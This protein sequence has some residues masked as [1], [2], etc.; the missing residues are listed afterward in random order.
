MKLRLFF[1]HILLLCA[2][3]SY[4]DQKTFLV[5]GGTTGW[6]GQKI[7][8][9]INEQGHI[10]IAAQSRLE[11]RHHIEQ[12]ICNLKPDFIINAAGVVGRPNADWCEDNK[13]ETIR[14]NLIGALNLADI[15]HKYN[16]HMTNIG[17]GCIYEY[18][19]AHPLKSG[20]GFTE[21]DTPNFEGSFYSK[22]KKMLDILLLC[23]PNVL[24]LRFR[25]PISSDLHP[26]NFV[27]K[28]SKYQKII[29]IPN[30]MTILDDLLPLI[31][32]MALMKLAGNY[33]FVNPGAISHNEILELYKQYIDPTFTYVNF[34]VEEQ[35]KVLKALRS[36]T[37][38]D[39]HKLL[40]VF[41]HIP[42]IKT[43]IIRVF[44]RMQQNHHEQ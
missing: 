14:S 23:Y 28:I 40:A 15:A 22:T 44:E 3:Y 36:N 27:T 21:E 4:A 20:I 43:S 9:I 13:L 32:Q 35:S 37:E 10:A 2:S 11:D 30:S 6:I 1:L 38:L 17:T 33:N 18:D 26:R 16:I 25:M 42:H 31:S 34:S 41:P 12:E 39:V 24:N 7:V 8:A 5:F 19:N 29:N